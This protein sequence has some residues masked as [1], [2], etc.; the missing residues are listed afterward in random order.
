MPK[1]HNQKSKKMMMTIEYMNVFRA[2]RI[3]PIDFTP[4]TF[5]YPITK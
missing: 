5:E 2:V 3:T 4:T 1:L